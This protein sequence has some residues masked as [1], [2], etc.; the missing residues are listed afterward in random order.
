MAPMKPLSR[1]RNTEN[2]DGHVRKTQTR[3][4]GMYIV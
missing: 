4:D 3:H 2:H 1:D